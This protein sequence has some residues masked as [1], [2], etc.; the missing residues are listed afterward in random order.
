MSEQKPM[1]QK[2]QMTELEK[3]GFLVV[4]QVLRRHPLPDDKKSMVVYDEIF[5][6]SFFIRRNKGKVIVAIARP[7]KDDTKPVTPN[8]PASSPGAPETG[9]KD[10]EWGTESDNWGV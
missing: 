8:A 9:S 6:Q 7:R 4:N 2:R 3:L 1:T 10:S 5:A